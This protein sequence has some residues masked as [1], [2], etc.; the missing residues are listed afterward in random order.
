[1]ARVSSSR[2]WI[3]KCA[4][5]ACT[6]VCSARAAARGRQTRTGVRVLTYHRIRRCARDPFSVD[7][8]AFERQ[9]AW[10]GAQGRAISLRELQD[11]VAGRGS[12]PDGAVLVTLDDGFEDVLTVAAPILHRHGVPAVA[13]VTS[14]LVADGD[15]PGISC[16]EGRYLAEWQL[17]QLSSFGV[18][19]GSHAARHRS[20]G[21]IDAADVWQEFHE[22]K[23]RLESMLRTP[24]SSFAFPFGT[25]RDFNATTTRLAGEAGYSVAFTSQHGPIVP[26]LE[27]FTLPR[28]KVEGGD[29]FWM[30]KR[31]VAG[32][33]DGW[34]LIDSLGAGIQ[35]RVPATAARPAHPVFDE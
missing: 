33:L 2:W 29:T 26:G 4:R 14:G 27:P 17:L 11:Y 12:L 19:V 9:M 24:V 3:K 10:L 23:A 1:M 5:V 32:G 8:A 34:R 20:L 22:S 25:L 30:F 13:F 18:D 16:E 7:A 28:V 6:L 31:L 21:D 35:Q 15:G